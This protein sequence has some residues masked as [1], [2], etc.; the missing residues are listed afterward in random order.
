MIDSNAIAVHHAREKVG[1]IKAGVAA[2]LAQILD[3]H[4]QIL[5][6]GTV[7]STDRYNIPI[8]VQYFY[9]PTIGKPIEHSFGALG[10]ALGHYFLSA[11][12]TAAYARKPT[13]EPLPASG[14]AT[15][16][17]NYASINGAAAS[18]A[19]TDLVTIGSASFTIV[20]M[21]YHTGSKHVTV[22]DSVD[23]VRESNNPYDKNAIR[24][25][26]KSGL[27]IAHIERRGC[28]RL[29][30]IMDQYPNT[31]VLTATI[32]GHERFSSMPL[33]VKFST[34]PGFA[35]VGLHVVKTRLKGIF[36]PHTAR[37]SLSSSQSIGSSSSGGSSAY[38]HS[39]AIEA[40]VNSS[41][42]TSAPAQSRTIQ[43]KVKSEMI[44]W[45][46]KRDDLDQLFDRQS[47][48]QLA[49]LPHYDMPGLLSHINFFDYQKQGIRWLIHQE[50]GSIPAYITL[51]ESSGQKLWKCAITNCVL[52]EEPKPVRGGILGDDM[53]LG[54]TLQSLALILANPPADYTSYPLPLSHG[55]DGSTKPRTTLIVSP[56]SV[57]AN[58]DSQID[59]HINRGV[60]DLNLSVALYHGPGRHAVLSRVEKGEI[61]VVLTS[62]QTLASDLKKMLEENEEDATD[63]PKKKKPKTTSWIFNLRFHRL[64]LDEA[65]R[66]CL[67]Q[68]PAYVLT[69]CSYILVRSAVAAHYQEWKVEYV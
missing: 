20:G 15:V 27:P 39:W 17:V 12:G 68:C 10:R 55:L 31:I 2:M 63:P 6:T 21:K 56:L 50:K 4:P 33:T 34:S 38:A 41:E 36:H 48:D 1:H 52:D 29:S 67:C 54:K 53:G 69:H 61:D 8:D 46:K 66:E 13:P 25:D 26:T 45:E 19:N 30:T 28:E 65:V 59:Q 64:V 42:G 5:V 22:G 14:S 40:K 51:D 44:D 35:N 49:K 11:A 23:L 7:V 32:D 57:M 58:W 24:V 43:A 62:Y 18:A 16:T 9:K 37:E 3:F 60:K 47:E